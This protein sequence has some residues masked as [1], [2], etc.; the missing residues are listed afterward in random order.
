MY[1]LHN[2]GIQGPIWNTIRKLNM[3]LKATIK[4]KDGPT[5][6]IKIKDSIRQGGVLS[7]LMYA[8]LMDEIAKELEKENKGCIIKGTDRKVGCLLWMDDVVLFSETDKEMQEMLDITYK[9]AKKYHIEFGKDK[10]KIMTTDKK[11]ETQFHLGDMK[12]DKTETYKYLGETIHNKQ[13]MDEHLKQTKSKAEGALQTILGIAKDPQLKGIEMET[14]WKLVEVCITPILTYGSETWNPNKKEMKEINKMLDNIIKRILLLPVTTPREALYIETGLKDLRY[15]TERNRINMEQRLEKTK[16]NLIEDVLQSTAKNSWKNLTNIIH[17][18]NDTESTTN[19]SEREK[20]MNI[21]FKQRI[22]QEAAEKS[23]VKF[24][25]KGIK[26]W[27]PG[28]RQTY[29]SKLNRLEANEIFKLRTRMTKIK[30]NYKG[31]YNNLTCRGCKA[32]EETQKHVLE[33]CTSIHTEES[34]KIYEEHYFTDNIDMLKE[35]VKKIKPILA[36]LEQS[37]TLP[38]PGEGQPGIRDITR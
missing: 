31:A 3:N 13:K 17:E 21:K 22:E 36:R 19:K 10:S 37:E 14:I 27:N 5:R 4:T 11:N 38:D 12:M 26:E 7:V 16:N 28:K 23:K 29:L 18:N 33:E 15:I 32:T 35:T 1:A 9:V 6:P 8:L 24:L 30:R 20:N 34:T 25:L 2:N